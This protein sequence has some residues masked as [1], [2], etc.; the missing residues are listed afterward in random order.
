MLTASLELSCDLFKSCRLYR[1]LDIEASY[2][3]KTVAP[4]LKTPTLMLLFL[5]LAQHINYSPAWTCQS[6]TYELT[7]SVSSEIKDI[8][9]VCH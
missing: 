2:T 3:F 8:G 5:G 7:T 9:I 4:S 1:K 6:L